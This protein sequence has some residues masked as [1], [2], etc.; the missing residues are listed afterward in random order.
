MRAAQKLWPEL[1]IEFREFGRATAVRM[2]PGFLRKNVVVGFSK[3]DLPRIGE[4]VAYFRE[5]GSPLVL[6]MPYDGMDEEVFDA[7]T[8]VGLR[9]ESGGHVM[10]IV[11]MPMDSSPVIT[12]QAAEDDDLYLDLY[13]RA[14]ATQRNVT[15]DEIRFQL[16]NDTLPGALRFVAE[17]HGEPVGMASLNVIGDTAYLSTAGVLPDHRGRGV[18]QALIKRRVS[19]AYEAGCSI[20]MGGGAIFGQP[21]RN[22][23]RCGFSLLPLGTP[24]WLTP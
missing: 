20:A 14:F 13:R 11:P 12:V 7:L 21:M 5:I 3:E 22:F 16:M 2:K 23:S 19:A 4:I 24:W 18:Q 1:E 8:A 10:A 15:P 17:L 9:C 6:T